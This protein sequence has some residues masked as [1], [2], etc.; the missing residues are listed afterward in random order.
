MLT[1]QFW[2]NQVANDEI[3]S[4][5]SDEKEVEG[6]KSKV[7]EARSSKSYESYEFMARYISTHSLVKLMG[8]IKKVSV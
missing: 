5:M 1:D 2:T 7:F 6:I 4:D 8:P 3:F